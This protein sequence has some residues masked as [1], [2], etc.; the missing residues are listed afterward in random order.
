MTLTVWN[1]SLTS[2]NLFFFVVSRTF[3]RRLCAQLQEER[4]AVPK[5]KRLK[6]AAVPTPQLIICHKHC[7]PSKESRPRTPLTS[8]SRPTDDGHCDGNSR[9]SEKESSTY[10]DIDL[11]AHLV[12]LHRSGTAPSCG[13]IGTQNSPKH[14][15]IES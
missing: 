8:I 7:P 3:M 15:R 4:N 2:L 9:R 5:Q 13:E 10:T 12:L 1:K 11:A 6:L 14:R